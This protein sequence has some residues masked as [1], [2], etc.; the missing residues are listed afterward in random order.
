MLLDA[1]GDADFKTLLQSADLRVA[2]GFGIQL[3]STLTFQNPPPRITGSDICELVCEIASEHDKSIALLGG[4][5]IQ[6]K[7]ASRKLHEGYRIRTA[8]IHG[9]LIEKK[10]GKWCMPKNTLERLQKIK[11]DILLVA[12]GHKKQEQWI[13]EVA[14][15][16]PS[17]R[18]AVGVGGLFAF[19]SNDIKRAP[20]WMQK[21]GLEWLWRLIQEPSRIKRIFKAVVVFPVLVIIDRFS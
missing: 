18:I 3:M 11:P 20:G 9:G 2:D 4:K 7:V 15:E 14:R 21:I 19:L 16:L 12:L 10:Q 8:G 17:V 6:A 5:A 1:G 13:D